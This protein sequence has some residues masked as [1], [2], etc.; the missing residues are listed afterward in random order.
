MLLSR[1]R[2]GK[3]WQTCRS[4]PSLSL[5]RS[6]LLRPS[7]ISLSLLTQA[8]DHQ[9]SGLGLTTEECYAGQRNAGLLLLRSYPTTT[10]FSLSPV[11]ASHSSP[12]TS[13]VPAQ[14]LPPIKPA[15]CCIY[16]PYGPDVSGPTCLST[17]DCLFSLH[18]GSTGPFIRTRF[19]PRVPNP[20]CCGLFPP[21]PRIGTF[22]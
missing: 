20:T 22:H 3:I 21:F 11:F 13:R 10:P 18:C 8:W 5:F 4:T 19:L 17:S 6:V 1:V 2:A 7:S 14:L 12:D 15:A 9:P 16:P